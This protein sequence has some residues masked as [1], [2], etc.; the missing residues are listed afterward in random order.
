[1]F[2]KTFLLSSYSPVCIFG[3]YK[4]TDSRRPAPRVLWTSIAQPMIVSVNW[5]MSAV[6][7]IMP[8]GQCIMPAVMIFECFRG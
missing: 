1:M 2:S 6:G 8:T 7:E 5:L 3:M 4:N